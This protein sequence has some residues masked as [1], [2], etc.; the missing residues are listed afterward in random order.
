MIRQR[1][2]FLCTGNSARSQMAEGWLR[3]L[4]AESFDVYSA[5]TDPKDAIHPLAVQVM[6]EAGVDISAQRP[7]NLRRF[8]G[9]PWSFII[10]VCD[11]AKES[12]PIFP[13]DHEQIHWSFL[14]P[15][16]ATG[17]DQRRADVFRQV[18]DEI[19]QRITL[20]NDLAGPGKPLRQ[21]E[22]PVETDLVVIAN[23][24]VLEVEQEQREV[25]PER[26]AR[27]GHEADQEIER[28]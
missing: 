4:A 15:A 19:Q 5:G 21:V 3:H 2:L 25:I 17:S 22:S 9:E 6:A 16:A 8:I 28:P 7:K 23:R 1:V 24:E 26:L 11:R 12:C 27:Y 10:T 14:D 20:W 13:G 18:R